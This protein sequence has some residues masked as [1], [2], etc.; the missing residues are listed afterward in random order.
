MLITA[1]IDIGA[2]NTKVILMS[3][4][5]QIVGSAEMRTGSEGAK[6]AEAVLSL[7]LKQAKVPREAVAYIVA[8]G[9][10]RFMVPFRDIQATDVTAHA[11]GAIYYYPNTRTV[12]DIGAQ[13]TRASRI[14]PNGRVT[15]FRLNDKCAAGAGMFLSRVSKYLET[16]LDEM[17]RLALLSRNPVSINS[18]CAVLSE[19]EIINQ[20]T[21]GAK[22]E[23]I[24]KGVMIGLARQS[25]GLV[26]RLGVEREVTFTGGLAR[27]AGMAAV[28]Q[29]ELGQS[30]NI[31]ANGVDGSF[32]A[33]AI[34][35]SLLGLLRLKKLASQG[36]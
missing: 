28:L 27:N 11:Q 22:L 2:V 18:V 9:F 24:V 8:T 31:S 1:G 35:A 25:L 26:R 29:E 32:Y 20:I 7:A 6:V 33:G 21:G 16:P 23:D 30:V 5:R 15:V 36:S 13:S 34:G 17:G 14:E 10:G 4:E 12:L 19:T 3:E